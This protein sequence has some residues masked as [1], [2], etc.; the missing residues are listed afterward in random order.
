[1]AFIVLQLRRECAG[2]KCLHLAFTGITLRIRWSYHHSNTSPVSTLTANKEKHSSTGSYRSFQRCSWHLVAGRLGSF[3]F[4]Q[5]RD[6]VSPCDARA[7]HRFC[8]AYQRIRAYVQAQAIRRI[9]QAN[10]RLGPSRSGSPGLFICERMQSTVH[11]RCHGE[12]RTTRMYLKRYNGCHTRPRA[13]LMPDLIR[14][15][16]KPWAIRC[17]SALGQQYITFGTIRRKATRPDHVLV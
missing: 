7:R 10:V 2:F 11:R 6:F 1:V 3:G 4:G 12:Q 8:R 13:C 17:I 9:M 5:E 14:Y 15:T 16:N